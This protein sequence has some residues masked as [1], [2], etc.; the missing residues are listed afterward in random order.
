PC[1]A[2]PED[3]SHPARRSSDLT[4]L[5]SNPNAA[6]GTPCTDSNACTQTDT[7]QAGSC[8]GGNPVTCSA[9]DQCHIAGTCNPGTGLCSNPNAAD[10]TPC[11]DCNACTQTDTCPAGSCGGRTPVVRSADA[12][13]HV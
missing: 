11:N 3:Q 4:G 8:V 13:W 5:C 1:S 2:S 12:R 9:Q 10:G 6:D 7:C